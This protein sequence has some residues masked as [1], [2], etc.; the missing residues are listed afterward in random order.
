VPVKENA[1]FANDKMVKVYVCVCVCACVCVSFTQQ[2]L[3]YR[4]AYMRDQWPI[5]EMYM[6]VC[7]CVCVCTSGIQRLSLE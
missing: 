3:V 7:V 6:L 2:E 5:A 4:H 1:T